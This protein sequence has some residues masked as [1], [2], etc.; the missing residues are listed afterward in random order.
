[1]IKVTLVPILPHNENYAYLLEA[2]NGEV[3]VVDPGEAAPFIEILEHRNLKP[4]VILI[5]HHHW[6]HIDGLPDMLR[7]H[8]CPVAG[9]SKE[10]TRIQPL[11]ILLDETSEFSFGG[12][13]V[14]IIETPGHTHGHI[15]FYFPESGFILAADAMFSMGCGRLFEGTPEEMWGSLQKISTLPDNTQIYCGHEYTLSNAQFCLGIEPE[16]EA[17]QKRL[18]EVEGMVVENKPTLPV[19]LAIE[20]QTNIFLRA[21]TP[22]KFAELRALKDRA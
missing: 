16:N 14:Q 5:T 6:D 22:E 17:L 19:S 7:W 9:P 10:K 13:R 11:D 3:A 15:C 21:E 8:K 4:D 1:M 20:K 18:K 2:D 12:E